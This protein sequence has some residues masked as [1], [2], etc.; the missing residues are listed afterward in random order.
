MSTTIDERVVEMRFDNKQFESNV[1]TSL[2]TLDKLKQSL[3]LEDASKGLENVNTAAKGIRFDGLGSAVETVKS[4][5][6]AFEVVAITALMNIT[7]SAVDAGKRLV[8]S[9][10]M[11]Q[12][13]A[14][15]QKYAD[16]TSAVQTIMAATAKDFTNTGEQMDY[17]NSQLDKL[18]WFTDETS[19]NFL[20]MVS[21][22]G[23]F[24]S[25]S[26]KL[27][28][29]VTAMQGISTWAAI[30]GANTNEASRAMY[31][32]S[33]AIATGS[34]KLID[35]K[36]I[37]NAN[38]A[39]AE[40]KQTV[41]D[42]AVSL[43]TLKKS[44]DGLYETTEGN[45]VSVSN[46][47]ENLKDAWFTSEVLLTTLDKY[48]GFSDKLYE[49]SEKTNLTA[50]ELLQ[51]VSSYKEGTLDISEIANEAGLSVGELTSMFDELSSSSMELGKRS[52]QAAQEA[53]TFKEALDSVKDAVSTGW[54]NTFELIFG[55]YEEAKK[56]W[57][58]VA[59]ELY[60][61][62]ASSAEDRNEMLAGW[63][64]M[65][66]REAMLE[67]IT[68]AWEGLKNV[69]GTVKEAF[70]EVFPPM[71]SERLVKITEGIRDLTEKFK[72][73]EKTTENLKN[74]FKGIFSVLDIIVQAVSA[75][76]GG[77]K[78]LFGFLPGL[79]NGILGVTD[80]FGEWASKIDE[81]IKKNKTF[82]K[83]V[84]GVVSFLQS[85]PGKINAV[86]QKIT[87][88]SIGDAFDSLKEKASGLL[89]KLKEVFS[90]FGDV[91]TS[92]LDSF[93]ERIKV[94]LEPLGTLFDGIKKVFSGILAFFKKLSPIFAT[95]A[96]SIGKAF[97]SLGEA[98]SNAV[99]NADFDGLLDIVNGGVLVAIAIGIKKFM[100]SLS[101]IT[102]N[103]GGMLNS[104]KGILNGAKGC[105]EAWQKDIQ[106]N[107]LL[108]IAAA[109]AILTVS[110][111]AL[112]LIDSN[113]LT[114]ALAAV[115]AEFTELLI[116]LKM[117][118][119]TLDGSDTKGMT[120]AA[121]T[122]MVMS[123]A[124]LVLTFAMRKLA[125]LDW[126][127]VLKGIVG[128]AGLSVVLVE[129]SK[130]LS[131]NTGS[132]TKSAIGLIAFAEAIR[133][134][135]KPTKELGALPL[136]SLAKGLISVGILCAELALFLKGADLDN[137]SLGKGLGLITLAEAVNILASAVGKFASINAGGM[138]QGLSGVAVVLS[139]V[140]AF[141]KLTGDSK[142][143]IST[144]TGMVILGSAMLIFGEAIGNM[145]SMSLEQI[146]KGL[147]AMGASL[148]AVAIAMNNMPAT[149]PIIATGM[150][151]VGAALKVI[152]SAM[153][154]FGEMSWEEIAKSIVTLAGSLAIIAVAVRAMEG[155]LGGSAALL[156]MAAAIG[157]LT[158]ALKAL[159]GMSLAEIG[160]A[161]LTLAGAFAVIGVAGL[162][163]GPITPAI[164]ALSAAVALL[165]VGT[166]ACGAG[167]LA[168]S[169]GL[170]ALATSGTASITMLVLAIEAI[171]SLIPQI[172]TKVGEGIVALLVAIGKA[173]PE[174]ANAIM[175]IVNATLVALE[176][177][178]PQF[179]TTLVK[180]L[181]TVLS[182]LVENLP[183]IMQ[184]GM[185]VAIAFLT[186]IKNNIREI[187]IVFLEIIVETLE[188]I[189]NKIP[190]IV[191]AGIDIVISLIDGLAQGIEENA[192]RI[193]DAFIHLFESLVES[194]LVFLGIHSP[195]KTFLD[196]GVNIIQGLINGIGDMLGS[197]LSKIGEVLSSMVNAIKE[198]L[199]QF[200][201]KGKEVMTN[202]KNGIANK[203]SE[204]KSKVTEVVT[205][206][207]SAIKDKLNNF[208]TKGQ[209][210]MTNLKT[211]I[212][213]KLSSV[214]D[215]AKDVASKALSSVKDQL[216][217]WKEIGGNLI[218]GLKEGIS[219][220]A[221]KV[222]DAAKGVVSEA[223]DAAK[224]LLGIHSPS[225]VFAEIGRYADEGMV[226]GL[227]TYASRVVDASEKVGKGAVDG[228]SDVISGVAN[229]LEYGMDSTPTIRPVL[230]LSDVASGFGVIDDM[231]S[232]R[233]SI[234]L[235]S[236]NSFDMNQ[237]AKSNNNLMDFDS[238]GLAIK[239]ALSKQKNGDINN[240]FNI[241]GEN[242]REIADE[243][244]RIIQKQIER[245]DASWA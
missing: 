176:G 219:N 139:E 49:A 88:T 175:Q 154:D 172:L 113:K 61:V 179:V 119:K 237:R 147:L 188:G 10:T 29:A 112:S 11:D 182:T 138:I 150:V 123:A 133:L 101:S 217:K 215:A 78:T 132:I 63:K 177:T 69:L 9:L 214:K 64:D 220:A 75:L 1:R 12:V 129:S 26:V 55:N 14:G 114:S 194:V 169:V 117:L 5:F 180:L 165:G 137:I 25:N 193:R 212:S 81:S 181:K 141:T 238:L 38:M 210:L 158:P 202:I 230:D 6:S 241:T 142:K 62:F 3:K 74:T 245:R 178:I 171:L 41:I 222:V 2:S 98:I 213:D 32:L 199:G 40:F 59:N 20:D 140:A 148:A 235:A 97:G 144:A 196:I 204:V 47:N 162:V 166:L 56:L 44:G 86:F 174:L 102:E 240:T 36:S 134:L 190:D 42:T 161:L 65:G 120:K 231:I 168:L 89:D 234:D 105:F 143:V 51:A 108:K 243:I 236:T 115:T 226:I 99:E 58:K 96:T 125:A 170:T 185:D 206:C 27:D 100:D 229:A 67:A 66:G 34:V 8:S 225:K 30:S 157:M 57:T 149:T 232:S 233:R 33:Q 31:N 135:V 146:G 77:F 136:E 106:A 21:N 17:V 70:R 124:I 18:N 186:G 91:D 93:S 216:S 207:V 116:A 195:S 82:K 244:S 13:T 104:I 28:T 109:I 107:T 68:N 228:I 73:G 128:I 208:K 198:K 155:T 52:F 183:T 205:N 79:G 126:D 45:S 110:L 151:L 242:P 43:G 156:V 39:T 184:A 35:W 191:Q 192:P 37:E 218:D 7:N 131:K 118:T 76:F 197:L 211:G 153:S 19:Y 72:M 50:T 223:I 189:A 187:V 46:F 152:A 54:M 87:G 53:K 200:L 167:I 227:K 121:T 173:S 145:G 159:G 224:N 103:A 221:R 95:L 201:E 23:K 16:K 164:L 94:R 80:S 15:W 160:K 24:T 48:G 209:E 122:M 22:I 83:G 60:D 111:I 127:G 84:E 92:G 4:R 203:L 71:T 90:G 130:Q 163:L 239:D 85:I